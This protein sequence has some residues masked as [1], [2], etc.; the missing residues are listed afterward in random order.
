[1]NTKLRYKLFG[2][3]AVVVAVVAATAVAIA[4]AMMAMKAETVL[5]CDGIACRLN[6]FRWAA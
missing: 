1:M 4:I 2:G 5:S 3:G 6:W